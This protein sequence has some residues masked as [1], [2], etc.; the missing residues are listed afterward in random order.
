MRLWQSGCN[1]KIRLSQQELLEI[2]QRISREFPPRSSSVYPELVL[3]P[4]D[5]FHLYAYWNLGKNNLTSEP[6]D[7]TNFQ[8]ILRIYY[9]PSQNSCSNN[10][11]QWFDVTV[12]SIKHQQKVAVPIDHTFY[13]AVIGKYYLDDSF[14]AYAY[15]NIIHVPRRER[16][17]E[18]E[19]AQ[20]SKKI[21]KGDADPPTENTNIVL[22]DFIMKDNLFG[23]KI[24]TPKKLKHG[25]AITSHPANLMN[26]S[27]L[28]INQ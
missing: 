13:S 19:M 25:P 1:S 5:P 16:I 9:Q 23:E 22:T 27:G 11:K 8:V 20:S 2:S 3:L 28:G 10:T 21:A 12:N 4:V 7:F 18:N 6:N 26:D 17:V 24:G 15:S 14:A